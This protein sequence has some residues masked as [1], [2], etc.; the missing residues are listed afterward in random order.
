MHA[1]LLDIRND[2]VGQRRRA[3]ARPA[4][5]VRSAPPAWNWSVGVRGGSAN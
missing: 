1:E 2:P 4:R 3:P 5:A